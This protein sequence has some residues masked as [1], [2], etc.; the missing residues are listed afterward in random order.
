MIQC[1]AGVFARKI[2]IALLGS[3][4]RYYNFCRIHQTLRVTPAMEAGLAD[5]VWSLEELVGLLQQEALGAAA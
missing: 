5:H 4:L 2:A 1:D 3:G